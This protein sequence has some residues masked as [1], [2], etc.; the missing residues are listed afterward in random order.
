LDRRAHGD[1]QNHRG[2]QDQAD[3]TGLLGLG[4][5]AVEVGLG[6]PGSWTRT[7]AAAQSW[8]RW[9]A[10]VRAAQDREP[11]IRERFTLDHDRLAAHDL[12]AL[13]ARR[14]DDHTANRDV[15]GDRH[16]CAAGLAPGQAVD[17]DR[18]AEQREVIERIDHDAHKRMRD[19]GR[20][21]GARRLHDVNVDPKDDVEVLDREG[22]R[23]SWYQ[24]A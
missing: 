1:R 4:L 2:R 22:Y 11:E 14:V 16:S 13:V 9:R 21:H 7:V 20:R 15:R 18:G 5:V 23:S 17:V 12:L 24:S 19:R 3:W 6:G 8:R 10:N